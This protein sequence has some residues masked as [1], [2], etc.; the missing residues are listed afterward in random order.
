MA[1]FQFEIE[2]V[3][4]DKTNGQPSGDLKLETVQILRDVRFWVVEMPDRVMLVPQTGGTIH[5]TKPSPSDGSLGDERHSRFPQNFVKIVLISLFAFGFIMLIV[6][7][8]RNGGLSFK[9]YMSI[10]AAFLGG[11]GAASFSK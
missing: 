4:D 1:K 9:E 7:D 2:D 5:L 10:V 8:A 3:V 6:T 11:L